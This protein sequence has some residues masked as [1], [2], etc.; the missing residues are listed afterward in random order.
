MVTFFSATAGY[1]E[2]A[3]IPLMNGSAIQAVPGATI[4]KTNSGKAKSSGN[5]E[6][7]Q[8]SPTVSAVM[9]RFSKIVEPPKAATSDLSS[10][11]EIKIVYP[12]L[13]SS[14]GKD[15]AVESI[16][17]AILQT[18]LSEGALNSQATSIEQLMENF[19]HDF[20][21]VLKESPEMSDRWSLELE[22]KIR[23]SDEELFCLETTTYASTGGAHPNTSVRCQAFSL[24]SGALVK[25]PEIV[26]LTEM[27]ALTK[28][29]EKQFRKVRKVEP[30]ESLQELGFTF[31]KNEF[32]LNGNFLLLKE[33]LFF[34]FNSYEIAPYAL[35][36]TEFVLPW[37]DVKTLVKP[38]GLA[39]RFLSN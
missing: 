38:K 31:E 14:T 23:Y 20:E 10:G 27:P 5:N 12:E 34:F 8:L 29:A 24:K 6:P 11:V 32:A 28:L 1:G 19:V 25:L 35:G 37:S 30:S 39:D 15:P 3:S 18:M 16:N 2:T 26:P 13:H 9:K 36:P 33:G 4:E 21:V 17:A 22:V 7:I